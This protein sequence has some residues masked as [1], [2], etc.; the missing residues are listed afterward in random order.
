MPKMTRAQQKIARETARITGD[1]QD[2]I[3]VSIVYHDKPYK[4]DLSNLPVNN[5][6]TLHNPK[7][8]TILYCGK[9]EL[10]KYFNLTPSGTVYNQDQE[11]Q[12]KKDIQA[13]K[14]SQK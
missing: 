14:A 3:L 13:L 6:V 5:V 7:T 1:P 10:R 9:G 4:S 8:N 11:S 12:R 2:Y